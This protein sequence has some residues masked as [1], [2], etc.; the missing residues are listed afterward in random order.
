MKH[1]AG[2]YSYHGCRCGICVDSRRDMNDKNR[3]DRYARRVLI[4]GRLIAPGSV[5]HGLNAYTGHGC[6]CDVCLAGT[7]ELRRQRFAARISIDGRLVA[8]GS[9]RHGSAST[10]SNHGCRC[11]P[12]TAANTDMISRRRLRR[13]AEGR[14]DE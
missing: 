7:K 14:T 11:E 10:Y 13:K 5:R 12:C 4:D 1:G 3:R 2:A 9:V 8:P 6:R